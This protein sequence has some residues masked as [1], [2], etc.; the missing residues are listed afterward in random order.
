MKVDQ[1]SRLAIVIILAGIIAGLV[2]FLVVKPGAPPEEEEDGLTKLTR[3]FM[4]CLPSDTSD[5]ARD[6]IQGILD[7]FHDRAVTNNVHPV[8]RLAIESDLIGYVH[9]GEISK[10]E[11]FD[12]MTK[13]GEATRRFDP[14]QQQIND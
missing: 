3:E 13:V 14:E 11:L 12:L 10:E 5:E 1:R 9:A 8:D 2:V 6:E 4:S 7:R